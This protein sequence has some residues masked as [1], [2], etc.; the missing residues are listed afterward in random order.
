MSACLCQ[1]VYKTSVLCVCSKAANHEKALAIIK[2][3][4]QLGI[5]LLYA[6]TCKRQMHMAKSNK[7]GGIDRFIEKFII[8]LIANT[9]II[10]RV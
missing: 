1:L 10:I 8:S 7:N 3:I 5:A 6:H 4:N 9:Y 2:Y